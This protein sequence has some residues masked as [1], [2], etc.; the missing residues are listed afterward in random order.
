[1]ELINQHL[2]GL[3][4]GVIIKGVD[5]INPELIIADLSSVNQH[6]YGAA[7][8]YDG[9][10]EH[11]EE[12]YDITDSI[13]KAV[14]WRSNPKYAG[15]IVVFIRTETDKLHSL[16]EFE[17]ICT[18]DVSQYLLKKQVKSNNNAPTNS[19]WSAL[20]KTSDYYTFEAVQDFVNAVAK[21][22]RP[23]DAISK[24]MWRLNLLE[25]DDILGTKSKPEDRLA[26]N[27]DIIFA[28]GQLSED[29]RK[30]LSRSLVCSKVKDKKRLQAAYRSLQNF[31]KYGNQDSLKDLDFTTV[32]ELFSAS[33]K[34]N[35]APKETSNPSDGQDIDKTTG[36]N[37]PIRPKEIDKLVSE[38][39]VFGGDEEQ[40]DIS[41]LLDELDKHYNTE[42]EENDESIPPIGG[43]FEDR[44]ITLD[45]HQTG[46]R[47]IVGKFCSLDSWGGIM[48]TD[49]SVLRDAISADI[50]A[51]HRFDPENKD[52]VI[53]F[54]GG[55]DGNQPLFEFIKQFDEQFNSKGLESLERFSPIIDKLKA[56][57][58][59]LLM[60]L[61]LL[62]Y[63]PVLLFGASENS[64]N[65]LIDY[66][67]AWDGLYRAFCNNEPT[68]RQIKPR[69]YK[70]YC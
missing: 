42:T 25:D 6:L 64:K 20:E 24:N 31:Y 15:H 38:A 57:R 62:M 46:L 14:L 33:Q 51:V 40:K 41:N 59:N 19:F 44:V 9:I 56:A 30:K 13:E 54:V 3:K 55:I 52:A 12:T 4:V 28:I 65:N 70:F 50:K 29:S 22:K 23:E 26:Q 17:N 36:F 2:A 53:S 8:G 1:M 16:S 39:I 34:K 11:T 49:E 7:I 60:H 21:S 63:H 35:N 67:Q 47:K 48:E 61:D 10:T 32:Q 18:R 69:W 37:T 43:I 5:G 45:A 68:M 27:R 66:I 58:K